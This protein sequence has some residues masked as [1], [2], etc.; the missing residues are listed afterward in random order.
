MGRPVALAPRPPAEEVDDS[1]TIG[2]DGGGLRPP[3]EPT[4]AGRPRRGR[5]RA[6]A[7]TDA[8]ADPLAAEHSRD[9]S[10]REEQGEAAQE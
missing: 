6:R 9:A 1:P 2:A 8:D 3:K 4:D 10:P 7:V 5:S